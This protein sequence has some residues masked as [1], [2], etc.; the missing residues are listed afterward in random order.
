MPDND[1]RTKEELLSE[2]GRLQHHVETLEKTVALHIDDAERLQESERRSRAWLENSPVC[3]KIVDLDFNLKYM[4]TAGVD[5]LNISDIELYYGNPY[6]LDFYPQA[7]K[8][9]ML[10]NLEWVKQSGEITT[11]EASVTDIDGQEIWFHSTLVPVNDDSGNIDYII[12][13]SLD[14]TGRKI[15]E[16]KNQDEQ[17][18]LRRLLQIQEN[19]RRMVAH[20]IHDGF[21]QYA[22]GAYLRFQGM[23]AQL[24]NKADTE[25]DIVLIENFL[26][27]AIAE[28]RRMINHLRPMVLDESGVVEAI[29]HLIADEVE[30]HNLSIDY[31]HDVKFERL[32]PTLEG[33]IFRIVQESLNNIKQHSQCRHASVQLIQHG[34]NLNIEVADTGI[35]FQTE[36]VSSNCF[37]LRGICERARLFQG[38]AQIESKQGVG[39]VISVTLPIITN[40]NE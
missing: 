35:G 39:T 3:T 38:H 30:D 12:V 13:V 26:G 22:L 8:D 36:S 1:L 40:A 25:S 16:K 5:G 15:A 32:E 4:S 6:P 11:Q 10:E 28:G 18:L 7:F 19:E 27:K 31:Q 34:T 21:I 24:D 9:Q 14:V 29:K 2:I 20:D 23:A 37:G 33:S 17:Q